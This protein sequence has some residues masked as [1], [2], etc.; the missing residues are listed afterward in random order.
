MNEIV[1]GVLIPWFNAFRFFVQSVERYEST[2]SREFVPNTSAALASKNDVDIWVLASV[3]G[4]IQFV[5]TEMKAYR[6]YTVVPRLLLFIEELTNWYVRLNRDRLKG[7]GSTSSSHSS[8]PAGATAGGSVLSNEEDAYVGLCTLFEVL[9]NMT[10]IMAPFAPFFSEYVY[11]HLR[12][13]LPSSTTTAAVAADGTKEI[14]LDAIGRADSV[15]YIMLPEANP[16]RLNIKA[17]NNFK[18]LQSAVYLTRT[19]RERRHIRT[20]LPLKNVLIVSGNQDDIDALQYLKSYFLSEVNAW[21]VTT[22]TDWATHCKVSI[23]PNFAE[24]GAKLGS[25]MKAVAKAVQELSQSEITG[26]MLS[27]VVNVMGHELS[28]AELMVKIEFKGE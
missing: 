5:H 25:Q 18:I 3:E 1:R 12:K 26:F 24:L 23:K 8:S 22:S 6:L 20:T 27:G 28:K 17:E 4:L 2:N 11:Q 13:L 15:H 10:I 9:L 16:S 14:P 21:N 19:A 7:L